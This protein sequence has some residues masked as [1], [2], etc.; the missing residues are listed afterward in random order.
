MKNNSQ[1]KTMR[2]IETV[3]NYLQACISELLKRGSEHDQSKLQEPELS[4]FNE[5]TPK[6]RGL[7]YGS[8][9]YKECMK[10]MGIAIAHHNKLNRHHPEHFNQGIRS[11]NL[12]DILEMLCD[13]KAATLRHG[14]GNIYKSLA[15]NAERFRYS[16]ELLDIF[17]NTIDWIEAQTVTHYAKES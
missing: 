17:R 16:E 1:F 13:W 5:Y 15:I 2:H 6:L 14:D 7:T 9:E 10:G 12:I 11:M 4:I 3:R 8:D